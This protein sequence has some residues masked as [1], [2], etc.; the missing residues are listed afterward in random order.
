MTNDAG[1]E[2]HGLLASRARNRAETRALQQA[3]MADRQRQMIL[4]GIG[5][6][7]VLRLLRTPGF[8]A[9]AITGAVGLAVLGR[10]VKESNARALQRLIAW[11][12]EQDQRIER[13]AR[14]ALH[15]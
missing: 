10:A 8:Q 12:R 11:E 6:G 2:R 9:L 15:R 7:A 1:L 3:R 13:K 4:L 14:E 5:L